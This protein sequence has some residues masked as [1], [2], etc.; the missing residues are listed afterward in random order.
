VTNQNL[1]GKVQTVLGPISPDDLGPTLTHEHILFDGSWPATRL[2]K[3]TDQ[4]FFEKPVSQ[5]TLGK[6]RHHIKANRDNSRLNDVQTAIDEV[7]LYKQYGGGTLVEVTSIGIG[8]DPVGLRRVSN[9][10]G[11]NIV[12]GGSYYVN[13][14]HPPEV[15]DLT[16]DD[17]VAQ[18]VGDITEGV[19]GTGIKTG[20]IG[21]VGCD[22]P[23]TDNERK[24][25]RASARA[26][27]ITGAPLLIHPGRDE[28]APLE[29]IE[30]LYEAD[31]ELD[32]TIIG[33]LDRTVFERD[34]LKKIAE[35]GCYMEWDLFGWV[36]SYYSM[37]LKIDM[38]SDDQ[39]LER[40]GWI[41]SEGYGRKVVIA[42]DICQKVRLEKYGGHGYSYILDHIAPRMLDRGF[43]P[44]AVQDILVSN[45][46]E[47]LTFL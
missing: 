8:R 5:E 33:H 20:I 38:P 35:S 47:A 32:H 44:Q 7:G 22:W 25:L 3:A 43:T 37:N 14:H 18:I 10:T 6:I 27:H 36:G 11:V 23:L 4:A 29:I 30:V 34:T 2:P 21:E 45:P 9:A 28:T 17:I 26:Q 15:D 46:A 19:E 42:H 41:S 13:T 24:I 39:R 31:A 12:M 40:I 1:T 16:E